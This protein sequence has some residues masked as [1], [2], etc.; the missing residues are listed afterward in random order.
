MRLIIFRK[1]LRI[2]TIQSCK[3]TSRGEIHFQAGFIF[4]TQFKNTQKKWKIEFYQEPNIFHSFH[5]PSNKSQNC[6]SSYLKIQFSIFSIHFWI[7]C[8]KWNLLRIQFYRRDDN[9]ASMRNFLW[10]TQWCTGKIQPNANYIPAPFLF[11]SQISQQYEGSLK[12]VRNSLYVV[13]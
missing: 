13:L 2:F 10:L 4:W 5:L 6:W 1:S 7:K 11:M 12:S 3:C 8:R 9:L